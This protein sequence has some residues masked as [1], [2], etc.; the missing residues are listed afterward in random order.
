MN[1]K[2]YLNP[3]PNLW[4]S[5]VLNAGIS[6]HC[7]L[8]VMRKEVINHHNTVKLKSLKNYSPYILMIEL[9]KV[10]WSEALQDHLKRD[11]DKGKLSGAVLL[12]LQEASDTVNH[13]ILLLNGKKGFGNMTSIILTLKTNVKQ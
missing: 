7:I 13:R 2:F 3:N 1:N 6:D 8:Y 12:D 11:T 9:S 5:G 10:N 4:R